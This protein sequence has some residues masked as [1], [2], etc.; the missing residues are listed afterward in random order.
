MK[1]IFR[2][3]RLEL[4]IMFYSPIAWLVLVLFIIQTGITFTELLYSQETNQQLGRP[5]NVLTKVLFAGEDGIL[6]KVQR[7]LYLYIPILTMGLFSRET[8][9]GSIKLLLTSP[10]TSLQIILGKYL[11]MLVYGLILS[12]ILASFIFTGAISIEAIDVKFVLGGIL[13]VYLLIAAYA[14]I[15]LYMSSLTTYQVVAAV[16]TLAI[17]AVLNFIGTIGQEY[18]FIRDITYWFSI[19]GR[20]DNLVNGLISSNDIFW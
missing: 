3:A 4:S 9:S 5:L 15:G 13:G 12:L 19:S 10:V 16:S 2:I 18:D 7:T 20:T 17:L 14:A 8:S 11:S 1:K 6:A